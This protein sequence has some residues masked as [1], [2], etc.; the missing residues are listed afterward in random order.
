[1]RTRLA[2]AAALVVGTPRADAGRGAALV[3]Y[4]A[5]DATFVAVADV[6]HARGTPM[7]KRAIELASSTFGWWDAVGKTGADKVVDTIVV[8]GDV[9]RRHLVVVVDG[10]L[11]K[12]AAELKK[13]G[14][15][16]THDGVAYW[17]LADWDAAVIDKRLVLA[18]TGDLAAVI[19]RAHGKA[20]AK[21]PAVARALLETAAT[22][23][24]VFGG[25]V[26]DTAR[27]AAFGQVIGGE[28][29]SVG[30]SLAAATKLTLDVKLK[31]GGDAAAA[32]V[33]GQISAGVPVAHDQLEQLVG[34]D[35]ADSIIVDQDH[36][37]VRVAATLT[38]EEA[39]RVLGL[40]RAMM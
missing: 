40:L 21:G 17:P 16:Q 18:T 29:E 5:D 14:K 4:L 36:A 2:I 6:A 19:D 35:F 7:F 30:F 9:S 39:E 8:G 1:M 20:K 27:R 11:D 38:A 25:F 34:K 28:P 31:L 24:D 12:L 23:T 13:T 3:K 32:K 15:P 10:R 37:Q 22:G 26:L 33:S